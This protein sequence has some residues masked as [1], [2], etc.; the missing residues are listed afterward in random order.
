MRVARL[1]LR[2]V[3]I[4]LC[5]NPRHTLVVKRGGGGSSTFEKKESPRL[6][7]VD[8]TSPVLVVSTVRV[9]FAV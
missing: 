5:E 1:G 8:R 7:K 4:V 9:T 2:N 6:R 3:M